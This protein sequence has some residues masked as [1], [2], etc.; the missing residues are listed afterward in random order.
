MDD[1]KDAASDTAIRLAVSAG[2][3][4]SLKKSKSDLRDL[5]MNVWKSAIDSHAIGA[6]DAC[7]NLI[8][9]RDALNNCEHKLEDARQKFWNFVA[10]QINQG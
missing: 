9:I 7:K 1:G 2:I 4:E 5:M 3:T 8:E 6:S 10:K